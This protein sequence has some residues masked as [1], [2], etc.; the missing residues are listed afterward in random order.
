MREAQQN[1]RA[2]RQQFMEAMLVPLAAKWN[3]SGSSEETERKYA[4]L[5]EEARKDARLA[6]VL[7]KRV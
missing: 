6:S 4:R 5:L 3:M 2:L 1:G 7:D